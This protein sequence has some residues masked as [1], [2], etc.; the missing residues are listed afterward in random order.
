M[1][2]ERKPPCVTR[3]FMF[4]IIGTILKLK[5]HQVVFIKKKYLLLTFRFTQGKGDASYEY[6]LMILNSFSLWNW[7][8]LV[9]L[10]I[11]LRCFLLLSL[12]HIEKLFEETVTFVFV[13]H[14]ISRSLIFM[15]DV[16][17]RQRHSAHVGCYNIGAMF[18]RIFLPQY[19]LKVNETT[20][21]LLNKSP[22]SL[23][24]QSGLRS[25]V[26]WMRIRLHFV[27]RKILDL[28][29]Y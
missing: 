29:L 6:G 15:I 22:K 17:F 14:L 4:V 9:K 21:A 5:L 10:E 13:E 7:R 25:F 16:F 2:W 1:I 12:K 24:L 23:K 3:T 19:R 26:S 11:V 20:I 8:I 27:G 18:A 28:L